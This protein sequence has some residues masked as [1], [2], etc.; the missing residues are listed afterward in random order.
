MFIHSGCH[1]GF[2]FLEGK[3]LYICLR[4]FL[5]LKHCP[6]LIEIRCCFL[7]FKILHMFTAL[8]VCI[9]GQRRP[10]WEVPCAVALELSVEFLPKPSLSKKLTSQSL[11]IM[12][13]RS[14]SCHQP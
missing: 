7:S 12:V 9:H 2:L 8:V 3:I 6:F 13:L 11:W 14:L 10:W 1:Q 4:E 5:D